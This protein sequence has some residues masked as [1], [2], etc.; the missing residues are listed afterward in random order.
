M[1]K[2]EKELQ[3]LITL[4][5]TITKEEEA[6]L[7]AAGWTPVVRWVDARNRSDIPLKAI[8]AITRLMREG[9]EKA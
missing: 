9:K 2:A 3:G 7:R 5:S 1:P 8:E 4:P 6:R